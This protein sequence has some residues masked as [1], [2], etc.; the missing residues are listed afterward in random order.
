MEIF[1]ATL[2]LGVVYMY[3]GAVLLILAMYTIGVEKIVRF[4]VYKGY[5]PLHDRDVDVELPEVV[6]LIIIW[7]IWLTLFILK[8]IGQLI[9]YLY[10]KTAKFIIQKARKK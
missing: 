2:T 6:A 9:V 1:Y 7:P 5:L 3:I 4:V 10:I 8:S